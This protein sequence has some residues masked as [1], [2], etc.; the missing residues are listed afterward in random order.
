MQMNDKQTIPSLQTGEHV[1]ATLLFVDDETN[2]L[3]SLKRLFHPCGYRIFTAASGA[4]GLEILDRE[5]IDLVVSD[6]RMPE[7]NG[8]QFL[9]QV[10]ARWP[11]TVR[12]LLTGHAEIAATIDAINKGH[13]YRYIS[14]PWEDSD[15][16]LAIKQALHQKQLERENRGLEELTRRQNEELKDLNANLEEKVRART[17]EVRQTM[18][19]LEVANEKLKKGFITSIRVFSNL[20]EMR[21]GAIA[22]HSQ[23]VAELSRAIGREM[24][25]KDADA[26][27]VFLAALLHDVGK[28]GL[29]DA[30]LEKPFASLSTQERIEVVKHPAKGQAALMALDQLGGAAK[31]IRCHHEH[32]DGMGYPDKLHGLEIPL[33]ARIITVANEYDAV[34]LGTLTNKRLKQPDAVL[35]IQEGRGGRYDPAVVDAF[36]KVMKSAGKM[37]H[38][39]RELALHLEQLKPG[40]TLSRDLM[41][42]HGDLLLSKEHQLDVS[43]IEQIR[44]FEQFGEKLTIYIFDK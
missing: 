6:M 41:S 29:E 22:G 42:S 27:D 37:D 9:E 12:I 17:E 23:R 16:V 21:G 14:K 2:I 13:I 34:Q 26:Q 28:I 10:N 15:L 30:L 18:G 44:G 11:E 32:F 24:G 35:F 1:N 25:L 7:M 36:M 43:L 5:Y 3:S 39:V 8:A 19:F 33:G 40:M 20:I 4:Q 31:L 38:P